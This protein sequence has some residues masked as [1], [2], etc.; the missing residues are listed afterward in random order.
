MHAVQTRLLV[1]PPPWQAVVWYCDATQFVHAVH[2]EVTVPAELHCFVVY[3]AR[4]RVHR[5]LVCDG[6]WWRESL[7]WWCGGTVRGRGLLGGSAKARGATSDALLRCC[8]NHPKRRRRC[9]WCMWYNR[10]CKC[11]RKWS[12]LCK[13]EIGRMHSS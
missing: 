11:C 2:P 1:S 10:F 13:L 8:N 3:P 6:A 5:W 12:R 7:W 9:R 4:A